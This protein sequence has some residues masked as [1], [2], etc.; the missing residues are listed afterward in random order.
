M[1]AQHR[2]SVRCRI[3]SG[4]RVLL[5]GWSRGTTGRPA[6]PGPPARAYGLRTLGF[7]MDG[8][9]CG[10][11]K[12]LGGRIGSGHLPHADCRYGHHPIVQVPDIGWLGPTL[13][14]SYD[15][16]PE[17]TYSDD[18]PSDIRGGAVARFGP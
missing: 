18:D 2:L 8:G 17:S 3:V 7:Q 16:C 14:S 15:P 1:G 13:S 10:G 4:P 11:V 12:R 6:V 5:V 9:H